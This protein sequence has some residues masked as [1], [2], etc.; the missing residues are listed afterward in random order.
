M[1][2]PEDNMKKHMKSMPKEHQMMADGCT[3]QSVGDCMPP[4]NKMQSD[5]PTM[6]MDNTKESKDC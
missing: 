2:T 6:K 5:M 4:D 1:T 3:K